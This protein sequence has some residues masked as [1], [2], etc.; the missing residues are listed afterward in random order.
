LDF[1]F[2]HVV[3]LVEQVLAELAH[4][5]SDHVF[6]LLLTRLHWQDLGLAVFGVQSFVYFS[7]RTVRF[8]NLM[9]LIDKALIKLIISKIVA[10]VFNKLIGFTKSASQVLLVLINN[11]L[12]F[13]IL[14]LDALHGNIGILFFFFF[15]FI[16]IEL[17]AVFIF[18]FVFGDIELF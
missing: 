6:R 3:Q 13:S 8:L 4:A 18:L 14:F 17:I 7:I 2:E 16:R 11:V 9:L 15:E 12:Q 1:Q 5:L 10:G